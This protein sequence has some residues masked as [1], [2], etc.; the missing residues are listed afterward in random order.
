MEALAHLTY[1]LYQLCQSHMKKDYL[2]PAHAAEILSKSPNSGSMD[3]TA[4]LDLP[5]GSLSNTKRTNAICFICL[6]D[7]QTITQ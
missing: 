1:R 4:V 3:T 2:E 5:A 7:V 6:S